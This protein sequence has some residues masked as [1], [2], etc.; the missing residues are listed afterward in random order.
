MTQMNLHWKFKPFA[1]LELE[2]LYA[3]LKARQEVFNMEQEIHYTDPDDRDQDAWHLFAQDEEGE[4]VAYLRLLPP[5]KMT[6]HSVGRVITSK[7]YRRQGF[8][9]E[10]MRQLFIKVEEQFG[11]IDLGMSAQLYL[12]DFYIGFDFKT[13][14]EPYVEEGV[15]HIKMIYTAQH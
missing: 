9:Q 8:G 13:A 7:K 14:S 12:E 6:M 2:E 10:L 11:K 5:G 4:I 3:I 15:E 1:S